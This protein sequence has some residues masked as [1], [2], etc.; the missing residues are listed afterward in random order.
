MTT[1]RINQVAIAYL[2]RRARPAGGVGGTGGHR[3][4]GPRG[5]LSRQGVS[6][7]HKKAV[8]SEEPHGHSAAA[9]VG[10][11]RQAAHPGPQPVQRTEPTI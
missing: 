2:S 9:R 10:G 5:A 1:G 6:F 8:P 3:Y 7:V 11:M 4:Q